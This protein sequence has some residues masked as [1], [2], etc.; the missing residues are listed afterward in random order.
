MKMQGWGR[1]EAMLSRGVIIGER[2]TGV[3]VLKYVA[4]IHEIDND[5]IL[6]LDLACVIIKF[7]NDM[8]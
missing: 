7:S 1:F 8:W 2:I 5:I 6:L 4:S 3:M